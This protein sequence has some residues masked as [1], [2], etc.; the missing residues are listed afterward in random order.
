MQFPP[1]LARPNIQEYTIYISKSTH[2]FRDV[3]HHV[4]T[5]LTPSF[6][7]GKPGLPRLA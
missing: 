4:P 3:F 5:Y 1:L 7:V 2:M 6:F